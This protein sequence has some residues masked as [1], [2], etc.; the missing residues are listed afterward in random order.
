MRKYLTCLILLAAIS[1]NGQ[2]RTITFVDFL[3][4]CLTI[5]EPV[6]TDSYSEYLDELGA[7][8]GYVLED[9]EI[10]LGDLTMEDLNFVSPEDSEEEFIKYSHDHP[11]IQA[12]K[13]KYPNQPIEINEEGRL[14]IENNVILYEV[15]SE[16]FDLANLQVDGLLAFI[17]YSETKGE[18]FLFFLQNCEIEYLLLHNYPE[19]IVQRP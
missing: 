12:F 7:I 2:K 14:V 19:L 6:E 5:K 3:H 9:A 13:N 4:E 15:S 1:V 11:I 16:M 10:V 8:N 17:D 18:D